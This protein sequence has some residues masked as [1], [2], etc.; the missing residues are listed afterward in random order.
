MKISDYPEATYIGQNTDYFVIQNGAASTKKINAD[1]FRFAMFDNVP[2]M[3]RVLARGY[4][5]GS[6]FTSQQ[7]AAI[8]SGQFTN[9]WIGDYWTTGD[10]KWYIVDFDYWGACD[11]SIGRHIAVMPDRNTSSAV[12][13]RGEYCGGFRNSE[14][15]A[16]LNDNPK[17]NATKAYGLFGESHI[18]A[19][20]SW[21][22][23]RWDTDIK[24]G[25]T[26]REEG[27]RLYAQN[28]EVFKIK[29]TIPTEQMLFGAHIKQSFQNGSEG[30]YRAE[31]R[32]L[33]YFQLF[34]H[35]NPNENFWLRDQ[36]WANYFSAWR[37]NLAR[38]EIMTSSLGI[39]PVLAIGG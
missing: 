14:L 31:C 28:G 17:T 38:D 36:T 30:A 1:S 35:Q 33:R 39:R 21:F 29:V 13:H 22:E 25:G 20:N 32:Q 18:L 34:N 11:P 15:F 9:L 4:N 6:S 5:L 23:N 10:T 27:Y 7:K 12:M 26:V 19:H 16:A 2:M 8:S 24:Y 37:E 3:H